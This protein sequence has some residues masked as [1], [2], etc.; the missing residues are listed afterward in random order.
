MFN[1]FIFFPTVLSLSCYYFICKGSFATFT[2]YCSYFLCLLFLHPQFF[3][4]VFACDLVRA[5]IREGQEGRVEKIHSK[6]SVVYHVSG[7]KRHGD[8]MLCVMSYWDMEWHELGCHSKAFPIFSLVLGERS[9][10][11]QAWSL[12][13]WGYAEFTAETFYNSKIWIKSG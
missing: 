9:F 5:Q 13:K 1:S 3:L 4:G 6:K 11:F 8:K 2:V 12:N 10:S 7:V